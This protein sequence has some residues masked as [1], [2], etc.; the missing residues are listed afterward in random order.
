MLAQLPSF[1]VFKKKRTR[2]WL[3]IKFYGDYITRPQ[4]RYY[5]VSMGHYL[6]GLSRLPNQLDGSRIGR[7]KVHNLIEISV[8]PLWFFV[9]LFSSYF[10]HPLVYTRSLDSLQAQA[11]KPRVLRAKR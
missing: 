3:P 7:F 8:S 11:H 10:I 1:R 6:T 4:R 5:N 9:L 2:V